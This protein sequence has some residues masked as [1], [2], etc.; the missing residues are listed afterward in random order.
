MEHTRSRNE[1]GLILLS[2]VTVLSIVVFLARPVF[3][4][5]VINTTV[6]L[7][8][9]GGNATLPEPP[10]SYVIPY[11]GLAYQGLTSDLAPDTTL[12]ATTRATGTL[13]ASDGISSNYSYIPY[14]EILAGTTS[15]ALN[16]VQNT[17]SGGLRADARYLLFSFNSTNAMINPEANSVAYM[18]VSG[19]FNITSTT[20]YV[21]LLGVQNAKATGTVVTSAGPVDVYAH[22]VA[23]TAGGSLTYDW[24]GSHA[25]VVSAGS[26][27]TD[28]LLKFSP[29]ALA[30]GYYPVKVTVTSDDGIGG[31]YSNTVERTLRVVTNE[32]FLGADDID[33]DGSANDVEGYGDTDQDGLP[34]YMDKRNTDTTRLATQAVAVN[35]YEITTTSPYG[36]RLG[37]IA[38]RAMTLNKT[39][40]ITSQDIL[41]FGGGVSADS[42]AH[43][44]GTFDFVVSVPSAGSNVPVVIPLSA[45]I[46]DYAELRVYNGSNWVAFSE[47]AL[48]VLRSRLGS[49]PGL[50]DIGGSAGLSPGDACV[51][52]QVEDGGA[53]DRDGLVNGE[54]AILAGVAQMDLGQAPSA[55]VLVSPM[56]GAS[57]VD[58][59]TVSFE[60]EP[61]TDA[62][63][64]TLSYELHYC[65]DA[66]FLNCTQV[67]VAKASTQ[68]W[69][70][71]YA[72]LSLGMGV[73]LL[74]VAGFSRRQRMWLNVLLVLGL[75]A[76]MNLVACSGGG[77]GG[78]NGGTQPNNNVSHSVDNLAAASTYYWKVVVSDGLNSTESETWSFT[79]Q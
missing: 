76:T 9:F 48:N 54:I 33:G 45:A 70:S 11:G 49:S 46:P 44:G 12:F 79:T 18:F 29:A 6:S 38:M 63:G 24:S 40:A 53:N 67:S 16:P 31:V 34:D 10:G 39:T 43:V 41:A 51:A 68:P 7:S 36:L 8:A 69:P 32:P 1:L 71:S 15:S 25:D 52:I 58:P 73:M 23:G 61:A 42:R 56:D 59:T 74:G 35:N 57:G 4:V 28:P 5:P 19:G 37:N 47:D 30:S 2:A 20:P 13:E 17:Y 50:C 64:D 55:P 75:L 21:Q 22:A 77:G 65:D 62:D 3:S 26:G 72:A 66:A 27:T 14:M 60:W 78:G